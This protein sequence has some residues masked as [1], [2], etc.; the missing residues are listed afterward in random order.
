MK[1]KKQYIAVIPRK[2]LGRLSQEVV[3]AVAE[4]I[5]TVG[6]ETTVDEVKAQFTELLN[7]E[8]GK[9]SGNIEIKY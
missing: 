5:A 9:K 8:R 1:Y 6:N 4:V 7:T 2:G 3:V